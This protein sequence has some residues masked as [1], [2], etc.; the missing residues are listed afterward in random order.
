MTNTNTNWRPCIIPNGHD[1]AANAITF[2]MQLHAA[3]YNGACDLPEILGG[4]GM[5]QR[6][7]AASCCMALG[8]QRTVPCQG[9]VN[10]ML[11]RAMSPK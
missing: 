8:Q 2:D 6:H 10:S 4:I 3:K 9:H 11:A 1:M 5:L 7:G